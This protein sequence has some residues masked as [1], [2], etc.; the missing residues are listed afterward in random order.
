M[1][2][3]FLYLSVAFVFA[4]SVN[5]SGLEQIDPQLT[6]NKFTSIRNNF[7]SEEIQKIKNTKPVGATL[8]DTH[9]STAIS[10]IYG[11]NGAIVFDD[12]I[13]K[14]LIKMGY[15][16]TLSGQASSATFDLV[17]LN[18]D[19]SSSFSGTSFSN[20]STP[21][22]NITVTL[23]GQQYV[24][25]AP[26]T[27][28]PAGSMLT[29]R[30]STNG[31]VSDPSKIFSLRTTSAIPVPSSPA[32]AVGQAT[33]IV[34]LLNT[35]LP[36]SATI[37]GSS[38]NISSAY[39]SVLTSIGV[40]PQTTV[41]GVF[42][43][44]MFTNP[45][46]STASLPVTFTGTSFTTAN[47]NTESAVTFLIGSETFKYTV[48]NGSSSSAL[49]PGSLIVFGNGSTLA[50]S[51]KTFSIMNSSQIAT[52]SSDSARANE[53]CTGLNDYFKSGSCISSTYQ[54]PN[55]NQILSMLG[56]TEVESTNGD[57][58]NNIFLNA[59]GSTQTFN[60]SSFV[61]TNRVISVTINGSDYAY[62]ETLL[63]QTP[64]GV[65]IVFVGP[66]GAS[67]TLQTTSIIGTTSDT[68]T[69][70]ATAI[71]TALNTF[72]QNNSKIFANEINAVNAIMSTASV[73]VKNPVIGN[74]NSLY[75]LA[76][77]ELNKLISASDNPTKISG[78]V[79]GLVYGYSTP[80]DA[81]SLNTSTS[82]TTSFSYGSFSLT[83]ST[84]SVTIDGSVYTYT[85]SSGNLSSGTIVFNG[86]NDKT[87]S[88]T[89]ATSYTTHSATMLALQ[90]TLD[91][92]NAF[93]GVSI[94]KDP[95]TIDHAINSI[96]AMIGGGQTTI[97][98]ASGSDFSNVDCNFDLGSSGAT[99]TNSS[100]ANSSADITVTIGGMSLT[101]TTTATDEVPSGTIIAFEGANGEVLEVTTGAAIGTTGNTATQNA[102]AITSALNTYFAPAT[103]MSSAEFVDQTLGNKF[104]LS[105]INSINEA[106]S[107]YDKMQ[108]FLGLFNAM[109]T[110]ET[111][112]YTKPTGTIKTFAE[113]IAC[114]E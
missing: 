45:M 36:N 92:N 9:A 37:R 22:A 88:I 2:K 109:T 38:K 25:T 5:S 59:L 95:L 65:K 81:P 64:S 78:T 58:F 73:L 100:F 8:Q 75:D 50:N 66:N 71:A 104:T 102:A 63:G 26:G 10:R 111:I 17:Y 11:T 85:P 54:L 86:P 13:T 33:S 94:Y 56:T 14:T 89:L 46:L 55:N 103:L 29:F 96:N 80:E 49:S 43:S 101:H 27:A 42:N 72:F 18:Q 77:S 15:G 44:G 30:A 69:Q 110:G 74:G 6:L 91:L 48:P 79:S 76:Q 23:D 60:G 107:T 99:F 4:T 83:G 113:L 53:I 12:E 82:N 106:N 35:F 51:T 105:A 68:S 1:K 62:T 7:T 16:A 90:M 31:A 40:S 47:T 112:T 70:K 57:V 21:S 28:I 41:T 114:F 84:I 24:Y 87:F 67:L 93:N 32:T 108:A 98:G 61:A 97:T 39:D 34:G 3:N 52:N 20:G 19:V